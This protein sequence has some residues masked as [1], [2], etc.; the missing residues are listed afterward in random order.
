MGAATRGWQHTAIPCTHRDFRPHGVISLRFAIR[1][2][3][4]TAHALGVGRQREAE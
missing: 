4:G 2:L 1:I 3:Q